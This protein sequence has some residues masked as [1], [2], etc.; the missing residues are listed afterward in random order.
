VTKREPID[1]A[2]LAKQAQ[3]S[4]EKEAY[5]QL[6]KTQSYRIGMGA[7]A[8]P[9]AM[10]S[11]FVEVIL[12]LSTKNRNVDLQRLENILACLKTLKARGY[13]LICEDSNC[14]SCETAFDIQNSN[15]EY[16][17]IKAVMQTINL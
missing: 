7:R 1:I 15:R 4:E 8:N 5:I 9:P 13:T 17:A 3:V 16:Q 6:D 14:I 11:F 2:A 12:N 10:P